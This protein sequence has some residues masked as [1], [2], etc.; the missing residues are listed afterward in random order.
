MRWLKSRSNVCSRRSPDDETFEARVTAAKE[1]IEHHVKEEE[2]EL[3]P[4]VEKALGDQ[5]LTELGVRM[6]ARFEEVLEQGFESSV[7]KGFAKTSADVAR[8]HL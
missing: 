7:P 1:L 2:E 8:A 4:E 5:K 3:F 6:K